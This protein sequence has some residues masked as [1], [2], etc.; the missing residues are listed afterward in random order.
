[1][2][3]PTRHGSRTLD[4]HAGAPA[5]GIATNLGQRLR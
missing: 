2:L 1:V 4:P 5:A 3:I